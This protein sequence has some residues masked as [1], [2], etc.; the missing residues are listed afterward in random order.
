MT[1]SSGT[2]GAQSDPVSIMSSVPKLICVVYL[3]SGPSWLSP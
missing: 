3:S 1:P 2:M